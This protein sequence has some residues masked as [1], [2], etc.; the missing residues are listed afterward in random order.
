MG[1]ISSVRHT[2]EQDRRIA[3][4]DAQIEALQATTPMAFL[5]EFRRVQLRVSE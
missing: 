1:E 4:L 5:A 3:K 2:P